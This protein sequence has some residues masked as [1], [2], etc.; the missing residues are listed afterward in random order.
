MSSYYNAT[1]ISIVHSIEFSFLLDDGLY[2]LIMSFFDSYGK[3][4]NLTYD[5]YMNIHDPNIT[6]IVDASWTELSDAHVTANVT[7]LNGILSVNASVSNGS[8]SSAARPMSLSGG[9]YHAD[10]SD[11]FTS[12]F[13]GSAYTVT[14]N[15][16][17]TKG[18]SETNSDASF[19]FS[20]VLESPVLAVSSVDGYNVTLNWTAVEHATLYTLYRHDNAT[21]PENLTLVY[22]GV[23]MT[24]VDVVN[25]TGVEIDVTFVYF[26]IANTSFGP[27]APSNAVSVTFEHEPSAPPGLFDIIIQNI[28]AF[29]SA[30]I[31]FILSILG[32]AIIINKKHAK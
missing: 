11:V 5:F 9:S 24:H 23:G 1:S 20:I 30:I 7:D 25:L 32:L 27:S 21:S 13:N 12:L 16:S 10:F 17:D 2:R 29:F 22:S 18:R 8:W 19:T 26:V 15:A 6:V 31:A 3:E 4:I 28:V 14:V